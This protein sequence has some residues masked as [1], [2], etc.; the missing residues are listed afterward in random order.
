MTLRIEQEKMRVKLMKEKYEEANSRFHNINS[1]DIKV[2]LVDG[3]SYHITWAGIQSSNTNDL[4]LLTLGGTDCPF[5]E[6]AASDDLAMGDH[7]YTIGNPSGLEYT[8]TSG[9]ISGYRQREGQRLIQTDAPVNP[10]NSGG[11]LINS[12]GKVLG[13]NTMIMKDTQ[14]IGF[15]IPIETAIEEFHIMLKKNQ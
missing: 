7:V 10:G 1:E 6:S 13:I 3:S 4:A 8:V 11:P 5:L 15:A 14:G 9:I 12:N 2:S